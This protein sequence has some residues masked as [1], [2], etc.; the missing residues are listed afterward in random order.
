MGAA[1]EAAEAPLCR[2]KGP[3]VWEKS[4]ISGPEEKKGHDHGGDFK[5]GGTR[6]GA[7]LDKGRPCLH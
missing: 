6:R 5:K 2:R 1:A 3:R 7:T 4:P